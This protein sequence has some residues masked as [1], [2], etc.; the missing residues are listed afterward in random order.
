MSPN[1][2]PTYQ[3]RVRNN[4]V[5]SK[6][7]K[8]ADNSQFFWHGLFFLQFLG[9]FLNF[10]FTSFTSPLAKRLKVGEMRPFFRFQDL[11]GSV[12]CLSFSEWFCTGKN[13]TRKINEPLWMQSRLI[14]ISSEWGNVTVWKVQSGSRLNLHA[15]EK[16]V[17]VIFHSVYIHNYIFI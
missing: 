4:L 10:S 13:H 2:P 8:E 7:I 6:C 12:R 9:L 5:S 1:V 15:G 16:A 14:I 17:D 3:G 11:H